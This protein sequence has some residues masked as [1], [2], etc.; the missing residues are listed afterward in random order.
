MEDLLDALA[1]YVEVLS[2]SAE[3]TRRAEDRT[4]YSQHLAAAARMF[5][6]IRRDPSLHGLYRLI[7]E[8]EASFGRDFLSGDEGSTAETAFV[9]FA[10]KARARVAATS[11]EGESVKPRN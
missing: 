6:A 10:S 3:G 1:T 7:G 4:R 8:E 11:Y 5:A 2:S 9:T